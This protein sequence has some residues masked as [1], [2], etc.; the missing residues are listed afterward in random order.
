MSPTTKTRRDGHGLRLGD[1]QIRIAGQIPRCVVTTQGPDTG[2]KDWNTLTQIAKYR[3]GVKGD[4][5]AAVRRLRDRRHTRDGDRRRRSVS[6][7]GNADPATMGT[8]SEGGSL[9]KDL[10]R[11]QVGG[12]GV[13]LTNRASSRTFV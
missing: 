4:G 1:A 7:L 5:E 3:P 13:G 6:P 9:D 2:M 11:A 10:F 8:A 12:R